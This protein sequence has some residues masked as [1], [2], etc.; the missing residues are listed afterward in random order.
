[1]AVGYPDGV[2][3]LG[4]LT[5]TDAAAHWSSSHFS[6]PVVSYGRI[7]M[8]HDALSFFW[9]DV[10]I[11]PGNSGGALVEDDRLVGIVSAQAVTPVHGVDGAVVRIP[12]AR[13]MRAELLRDLLDTQLQKDASHDEFRRES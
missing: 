8:L 9:A 2:S 3:V 11:Y 13:V 12:F 7:A 10:S 4:R 5:R 1:M 6:L